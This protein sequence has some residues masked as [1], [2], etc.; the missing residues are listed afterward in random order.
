MEEPAVKPFQ[1]VS[2]PVEQARSHTAPPRGQVRNNQSAVPESKLVAGRFGRMFRNLPSYEPSDDVIAA[3]V[4]QLLEAPG[5]GAD[6]DNPAIP[7][8]FTYLGQ[9]IDHD[10]TFDPVSSLQRQNDPDGLHNFRTPNFD[11][12]SVYGMG[13]A[14]QPY[15]YQSG[16]PDKFLIGQGGGQG[17]ED[18]P[19]NVEEVPLLGDPRNDENI[20][21][22][23]LQLAFLKLHNQIV[24]DIRAE[25]QNGRPDLRPH[26]WSDGSVFQEAQRLTRWHYQ[27][28]VLTEFLP[29]ICGQDIVNELVETTDVPGLGICRRI[30]GLQYYKPEHSAY[31]PVEFSVAAYRYGHSQVRGAYHLN[32]TLRG[33]RQG[34]PLL[35][36][37]EDPDS[38]PL[39]HLGG[40]RILPAFWTLD[41][42]L[43]FEQ[44]AP[45]TPGNDLVSP[46][47]TRRI[48]TRLAAGLQFLPG[49]TDGIRFLGL[50]NLLRGRVMG[51][52]SGQAVARRLCVQPLT[53]EEV[54]LGGAE[55]P[56]WF[57][58]LREAEVRENGERLGPVGARIVAEVFLG[59]MKEDPFSFLRTEPAWQPVLPAAITGDPQRWGMADLLAYAFPNDGR[60]LQP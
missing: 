6:L 19:R 7:S 58:I 10:L 55:A 59:I 11:L 8:G 1:S 31:I 43:F 4:A 2:H 37:I 20:I 27:W 21:V 53:D 25:G 23:Q 34:A 32:D 26:L 29:L 30:K 41:W 42:R 28:V 24:D 51:L 39:G 17:E 35:I 49:V 14:D 3:C 45:G 47:P 50:R 38:D 44:N 13:R 12:D 48:D 46:Q 15:L 33:F 16:D 36:F 60:T 5:G 18:L 9:F 40:G 54:N 52:P 56:L 57:Y 22:S